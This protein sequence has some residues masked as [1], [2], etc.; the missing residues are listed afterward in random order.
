LAFVSVNLFA[1]KT[2]FSSYES[3]LKVLAKELVYGKNDTEKLGRSQSVF[4][5]LGFRS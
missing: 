2:D 5:N 1:Q 4:R 3:E